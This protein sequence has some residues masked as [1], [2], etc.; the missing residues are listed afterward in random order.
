MK[1]K[2][3]G[4]PHPW[5]AKKAGHAMPHKNKH[6][7]TW[8]KMTCVNPECQGPCFEFDVLLQGHWTPCCRSIRW[9]NQDGTLGGSQDETLFCAVCH[10]AVC[11]FGIE[12]V[13]RKEAEDP[14]VTHDHCRSDPWVDLAG[15]QWLYEAARDI[16]AMA[17][18]VA[19]RGVEKGKNLADARKAFRKVIRFVA[20]KLEGTSFLDMQKLS[21]DVVLGRTGK[22]GIP[23]FEKR[24]LKEQVN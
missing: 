23:P 21:S 16:V 22:F 12:G 9:W 8:S 17:S 6:G 14:E 19:T 13:L 4:C 11:S 20:K 5:C 1:T 2:K 24:R 7:R 3:D 15:R 18:T 10:R